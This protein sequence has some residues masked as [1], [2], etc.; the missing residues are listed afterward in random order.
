LNQRC[1]DRFGTGQ[2]PGDIPD[3]QHRLVLERMERVGISPPLERQTFL[4]GAVIG[5][6]THAPVRCRIGDGIVFGWRESV[7]GH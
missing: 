2:I 7:V 5:V 6:Q 1:D 4:R 3:F